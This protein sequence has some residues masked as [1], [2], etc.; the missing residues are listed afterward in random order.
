[1]PSSRARHLVTLGLLLL[2]AAA[3][4][5]AATRTFALVVGHNESLDEG[6]L[7]LSY[8]DDDA[9]RYAELFSLYAEETTLLTVMDRETQRLYP[10]LV[11][12]AAPPTFEQL[13]KAWT[14]LAAKAAE[15]RARGDRAELFFVYTGH[16]NVDAGGRGYV[17][18]QDRRFTRDDLLREIVG[19]HRGD[20]LHLVLD[21]CHAWLVVNE[22]GR[23]SKLV[24]ATRS[25]LDVPQLA[26]HPE[27]GLLLATSGEAVTHEWKE[28]R[29]G[30]FSHEL[31]TAM[32]GAADVNGDGRVEYSEVAA[33]IAA[34][35]EQVSDPRGRLDVFVRPP[36]TDE[37]L[38]L[39]DLARRAPRRALL[40]APGLAGRWTVE[41]QRGVRYADFR[42]AADY[43]LALE[44][45]PDRAYFVRT[46]ETEAFVPAATTGAIALNLLHFQA[47]AQSARGALGESLRSGLFA[48]PYGDGF[49]RGYVS[50]RDLLPVPPATTPPGAL[51]PGLV[52]PTTVEP[53]PP[54]TLPP[55]ALVP[56]APA[57]FRAR[58]FAIGA[59]GGVAIAA[60]ASAIA[61][62]WASQESGKAYQ[63]KPLRDEVLRAQTD[64]QNG[65]ANV[66]WGVA[67]AAA[68]L[69]I[70][71]WA[72]E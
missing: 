36:A 20:A 34:A 5:R 71:L 13:R 24:E 58:T 59:A 54:E 7:P 28:Y 4:A 52:P 41:D 6:V 27:V 14:A 55:G 61:F 62:K 53:A 42:K 37:R 15:A 68:A 21:A 43:Q 44:L 48:A 70:G 65:Y 39:V 35:N 26:D 31:R 22:R 10:Q 18:L 33:F 1:M 45:E 29:S 56:V 32:L 47:R 19:A 16:G 64:L 66:S 11:A 9:A 46:D 57:P 51:P 8:A 72:T 3:P 38:P 17:N 49:Y 25:H 50:S 67:G 40:V 2:A 69:A 30:V 23:L 12:R 63:Q 60:A